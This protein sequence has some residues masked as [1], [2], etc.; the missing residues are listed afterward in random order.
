MPYVRCPMRAESVDA[1]E[2]ASCSRL[3]SVAWEAAGG[4]LVC[5]TEEEVAAPSSIDPRAD[6]A[7]AAA[8]API[9][10]MLPRTTTCV[11]ADLPI[12]DVRHLMAERGLRAVPVVDDEGKL[13]GLV[14]RSQLATAANFGEIGD[15]M[16]PPRNALLEGAPVAHAIA[17][18][19]SEDVREIPI[20]TSEG[21]VVGM[22]DAL[23][24]LRWVAKRMGWIVPAPGERAREEE[25]RA[26]RDQE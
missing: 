18:M 2:C 14:S 24:A 16:S 25:P 12:D 20:V 26:A 21:H 5:V 8:H 19:A 10:E 6:C 3:R 15:M 17:L 9:Y 7:E 4:A 22:Y 11:T 1:L 13:A 23:D